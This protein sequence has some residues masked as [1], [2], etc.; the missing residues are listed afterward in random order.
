MTSQ[1]KIGVSSCLTGN[2]VRYDGRHKHNCYIT[3]VLGRFFQL[4]PVCPEVGCGMPIPREA[5]CL[6]GDPAAPRLMTI[7]TRIDTTAQML[8]FCNRK[9]GE[10]ESEGLCGFIFKKGSPSCGLSGVKVCN[11]GVPARRGSGLFAAAMV[12]HF[13]LLPVEEEGRLND[14]AIRENFIERVFTQRRWMDFMLGGQSIGALVT[15]HTSHKLLIMAHSPGHYREMGAVVAHGT[16]MPLDQLLERY[17][18]LL[19]EAMALHATVRKQTNVLHHVMGYFRKVLTAAEKAEL[20]EVIA[21]YHDHLV[22][23][24]APLTL[25]RNYA[26]RYDQSYLTGQVYLNQHPAE[27]MLRNHV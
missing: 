3:D 19:M 15:F 5:M 21:R 2:N 16:E 11:R 8:E 24:T 13:P 14:P 1:I 10:L 7:R 6:A 4:V 23:L 17:R 26:S 20:V 22:P 25:L 9:V 18:L 27:L 12:G